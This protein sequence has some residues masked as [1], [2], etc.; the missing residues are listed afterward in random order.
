MANLTLKEQKKEAR[1]ERKWEDLLLHDN[2]SQ[3]FKTSLIDNISSNWAQVKKRHEGLEHSL[4]CDLHNLVEALLIPQC[5]KH[6]WYKAL[7]P[8]ELIDFKHDC[9]VYLAGEIWDFKRL[10]GIFVDVQYNR[11]AA[12]RHI[13]RH[14][15]SKATEGVNSGLKVYSAPAKKLNESADRLLK[16]TEKVVDSMSKGLEYPPSEWGEILC[17][18]KGITTQLKDVILEAKQVA[19]LMESTK[20]ELAQSVVEAVDK[21]LAETNPPGGFKALRSGNLYQFPEA[22]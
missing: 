3:A 8:A 10:T 19:L 17:E 6:K 16:S 21:K 11:L 15:R 9:E 18:L 13:S 12:T 22:K 20:K 4:F 7:S 2:K 14:T 1:L 5:E